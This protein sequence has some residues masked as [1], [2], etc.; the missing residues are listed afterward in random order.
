MRSGMIAEKVGMTR[1]FTDNGEHIPVTVLKVDQ[2]Q[3]IAHRTQEKDGYTA[4]QLGVG[5]AKVKRTS[6]QLRGH[7]AKAQ[8]EPK[9]KM[10]EFRVSEDA[11]IEI[12]SEILANHFVD[13]QFIDVVGTSIGKGFAGSMKRHNFRGLR[14]SH[15]VSV[16]H[17]SHGSTGNSQEPGRVWKGKKLAGQM[18]NAR[19]TVQNLTVFSTDVERGIILVRGS[20]PG[21]RGRYVLVRDSI[22]KD[23]PEN[24]P[25]PGSFKISES[26][27]S[28][29]Q[30]QD[31]AGHTG[32]TEEVL[33]SMEEEA[34]IASE[35]EVN[36]P[37]SHEDSGDSNDDLGEKG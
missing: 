23:L 33:E 37:V 22:K 11:L 30:E 12:G 3:V 9:R 27:K 26:M 1:V 8:V 16:S 31:S 28:E 20:I 19:I 10:A 24:A 7:F 13:G 5:S 36:D 14:A 34:L 2:C 6:K 35:E 32:E 4:L 18:G 21:S 17:R 29:R 15:G 25:Y